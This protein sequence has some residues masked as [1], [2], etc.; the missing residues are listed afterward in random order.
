MKT[1]EEKILDSARHN[2]WIVVGMSGATNSG[3]STVTSKL[4]KA[5]THCQSINQD[6]YF[7]EPSDEHHV[8]VDLTATRRHQNWERLESVNWDSMGERIG[9]IVSQPVTSGRRG[10]LIL[11]GHIILNYKPIA[12]ICQAKFFV[13]LDKKTVHSRRLQRNYI[14]AD[15]EGYFDQCVWP[16][17]LRNKE[18]LKSQKNITYIDGSQSIDYIFDLV[19]KKLKRYQ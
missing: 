6:A 19:Y 4:T 7:R 10:F 17:Y 2:R 3:K 11:D 13:E 14:P 5:L 1:W 9:Q 16:M 12:H 18:E 8:W 15:P